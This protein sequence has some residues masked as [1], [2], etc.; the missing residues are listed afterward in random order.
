MSDRNDDIA[1]DELQ[2]RVLYALLGPA[3]RLARLFATPLTTLR[4]WA[5]MAYYHETKRHDLKM[6]EVAE[7]MDV[8][9]SKV[10]LLSRALKENFLRDVED[11][12]LPRRIEFMLWAEPL[13]LAKIKQVLT[14]TEPERV[15]EVVQDL[16]EQG[17]VKPVEADNNVL[18]EL[19][20]ATDRRVWDSWLAR[21]DGLNN[22]LRNVTD[23]IYARFFTDE[24][25]AFARTLTFRIRPGDLERL[26]EFY[27]NQLF[28]IVEELDTLAEEDPDSAVPIS[29]SLFWAPYEFLDTVSPDEDKE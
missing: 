6:K 23:A 10:A 3:G 29:L 21:I 12:E 18:Y 8:S 28:T 24:D 4:D 26:H 20:I 25:A 1:T 22:V 11:A 19:Q 16:V 13:S 15:E 7:L 2:D 9:I 27:E 5:E 14:E 17:R